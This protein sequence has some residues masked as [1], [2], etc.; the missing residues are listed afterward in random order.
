MA[1]S[2]TTYPQ[3]GPE[4]LPRNRLLEWV[5]TSDHKRIGLL[6]I[7]TTIVFFALGGIESLLMRIQLAVPRNTFLTPEAYNQIFTM[8]GT[9]MIFL[10]VMPLLFGIANYIVPLQIGARDMTFPKLNALSFW[11]LLFGGVVL[12]FSWLTGSA[13]D[14]GWF[15][16]APL[17]LQPYSTTTAVDYWAIGLL[18][19]SAGSIAT[20]VN[21]VVTILKERAPGM[22]MFRMPLF[23]WMMLITGFLTVAAIPSLT[24]AQIMLLFDR[25]LGAAFFDA[26]SGGDPVLWQHLF[27]YFGHPEVYI[28][29]LP[30]FGMISEMIPVFS[31]KPIFGYQVVALSGVAIAFLSLGVWAHHMFAVGLG[32]PADIFFGF[33]SALIA[34]P[35]GIKVFSWLAT[36]WGG[37]IHFTTA[38]KF[39]LAFLALFTL[40][41][42][43]GVQFATV[44]IDWRT[45]DTY[46]VVA[47]FHF[48]LFGGTFFAVLGAMYYWFPK[49]SGRMLSER[50]G[51]WHFWLTFVGFNM[52]FLPMHFVGL[53]GM[54][55][56]VYTYPDLPGLDL[57]NMVETI[58]AFVIGVSVLVGLWNIW[59]SL[60]KGE[61][62]GPNPWRAWTLEWAT[63][64]PPPAYNFAT[65]P[66][67]TSARPLYVPPAPRAPVQPQAAAPRPAPRRVE[68]PSSGAARISAPTLGILV[69]IFSEVTF[70]GALI[71]AYLQFRG[72]TQGGFSPQN[73]EAFRVG[74]FSLALFASSA[75]IVRA[76]R[77]LHADDIRG[78]RTWMIIT[79]LLG[80]TFLIGQLTEYVKLFNEG[81]SLATNNYAASFF[82]LTGFHGF[83][84]FVGLILLCVMAGLAFAGEF[85][86][87]G[88]SAV[89]AMSAYW[90]FVDAVWV[91]VFS[92]V[93]LL[94]MI[95]K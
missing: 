52:T 55:R 35:T 87:R 75:T 69:F 39:S 36:T 17:T 64:S 15:S 86:R 82:T 72:Q 89:T 43:T 37:Q 23:T 44:P 47:H 81:I 6:Y 77:R 79:A 27:W 33:S 10:V 29:A 32:L 66:V 74:L 12:N 25:H 40:G 42:L 71:V 57:W 2:T 31:R 48:V 70:F 16:N 24:A 1:T 3:P 22:T 30:A 80:L 4:A 14:T 56:R 85:R 88:R 76:E 19:T 78:F 63:S 41:G 26:Q 91:V 21:F 95:S 49:M 62:A 38:M 90:H 73:L 34:I 9:T 28:M 13:P 65:I 61:I 68:R 83:H 94:P 50:L 60:R 5:A 7:Y 59:T 84:V 93:Y 20:A 67:V 11:L 58:G 53:L 18:I 92:L 54:P 8:H 45:H 51:S 46:Y